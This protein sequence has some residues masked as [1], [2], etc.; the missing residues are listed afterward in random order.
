MQLLLFK[1]NVFKVAFIDCVGY[2]Q[3]RLEEIFYSVL[4]FL[5]AVWNIWALFFIFEEHTASEIYLLWGIKYTD[6]LLR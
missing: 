6:T 2:S 3:T 5:T 1:V 4:Y